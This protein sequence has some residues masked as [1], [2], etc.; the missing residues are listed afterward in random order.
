MERLNGAIFVDGAA[1][2]LIILMTKAFGWVARRNNTRSPVSDKLLRAPGESLL[3]KMEAL[4][5][6]NLSAPT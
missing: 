2:F 5:C 6:W 4:G 1:L 3:R